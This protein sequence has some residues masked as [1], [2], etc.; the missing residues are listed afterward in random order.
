MQIEGWIVEEEITPGP[1]LDI[2]AV[3]VRLLQQIID[4]LKETKAVDMGEGNPVEITALY[5]VPTVIFAFLD[6]ESVME[7]DE[8]REQGKALAQLICYRD[9]RDFLKDLASYGDEDFIKE[10]GLARFLEKDEPTKT[11]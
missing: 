5:S 11:T 1:D 10:F 4:S 2:R 8:D 6:T 3:Y 7:G 9:R